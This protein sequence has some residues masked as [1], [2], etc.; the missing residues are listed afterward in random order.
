MSTTD[1]PLI[2]YHAPN[3]RSATIRWLFEELGA[4]EHELKVFDLKK[5]DHK[6]P[7]YLAIN[8]MGKVPAISHKGTVITEIAAIAFYLADLFPKAGLAPAIGDPARGTYLRWSVFYHACVE[9][10]VIDHAFKRPPAPASTLPYGTYEDTVNALAGAL[11]KG[12]YLL[13]E[14]FSAADV[15]VGSGVRYLLMFKLLPDRP[16]FTGYAERLGARAALQRAQVKD[17][18]LAAAQAT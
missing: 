1:L 12:P 14:R 11:A 15:V 8:P 7:E 6:S 10:A 3:S 18:E 13:G 9:P 17:A 16:E 4:P 5:G 2:H